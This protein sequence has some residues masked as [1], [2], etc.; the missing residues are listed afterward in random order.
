MN[1]IRDWL[2][3]GDI[4]DA[5]TMAIPTDVAVTVCQDAVEDNVGCE[6]HHFNLAD[7]EVDMYGG[8]CTYEM[9]SD[10]VDTVVNAVEQEDKSVFVHCHAGQ[11]RSASVC[12]AALGAI[13]NL[14]YGRAYNEVEDVRSMIHP[15]PTLI[16]FIKQYLNEHS[17]AK[18]RRIY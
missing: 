3:I 18:S 16:D 8:E 11:S 13:E 12:I 9:F 10:A 5:E 2:W 1:E 15:N 7:G 4:D 17:D 14:T 6:Y